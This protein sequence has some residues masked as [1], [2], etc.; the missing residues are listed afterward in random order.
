MTTETEFEIFSIEGNIGSGKSTI[1]ERLKERYPQF[2]YLPEP[3]DEW[4]KI[5]DN[6]GVT[7]LEKFYNDKKRYS[8][9]FQMMVSL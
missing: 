7:I 2:I 1:I 3:V 5:K 9:S 6:S 8:F 4:N